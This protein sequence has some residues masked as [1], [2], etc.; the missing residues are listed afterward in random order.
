YGLPK[1]PQVSKDAGW[2]RDLFDSV[3]TASVDVASTLDWIAGYIEKKTP[4]TKV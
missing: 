4:G 1:K 2:L 3:D